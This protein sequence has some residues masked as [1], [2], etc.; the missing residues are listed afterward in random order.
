M[1]SGPEFMAASALGSQRGAEAR[2]AEHLPG[3]L[4][5]VRARHS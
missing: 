3:R 4:L 1:E 5:P 2:F